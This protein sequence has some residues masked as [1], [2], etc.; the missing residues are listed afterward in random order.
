MNREP[1]AR[2]LRARPFD[3]VPNPGRDDRLVASR[4]RDPRPVGEG[5][6]GLALEQSDPLVALLLEPF[7]GRSR[8]AR[9]DDALHENVIAG[10]DSLE[11]LRGSELVW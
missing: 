6:L 2:W 8:L 9:G 4:E 3:P 1:D 11:Q 10:C 7:A 5:Q